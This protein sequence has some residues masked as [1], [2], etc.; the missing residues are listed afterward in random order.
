MVAKTDIVPGS[1]IDTTSSG[2]E[3]LN[4]PN[5]AEQGIDEDSLAYE[6]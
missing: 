6:V 4:I 3:E 2:G 5:P 1:L